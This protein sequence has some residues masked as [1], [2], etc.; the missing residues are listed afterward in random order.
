MQSSQDAAVVTCKVE[1]CCYNAQEVCA[2]PGIQVG[3]PHPQCDTF[4]T[5]GRRAAGH[6]ESHVGRCNVSD[7]SLNAQ[8]HCT[9]PGITIGG[10]AEHADC[11]TYRV[12]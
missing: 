6:D 12:S 8:L 3:G 10:H 1:E 5:S 7:C 9:A 11:E 4:T 2:A